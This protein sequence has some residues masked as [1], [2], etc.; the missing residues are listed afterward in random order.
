MS[1]INKS[2]IL[3]RASKRQRVRA[4]IILA[5]LGGLFVLIGLM[6]GGVID[7]EA[8]L[9][10]CGFKQ[11]HGLPC[12]TCGMTHS[13]L[14]FARGS[15]LK[16]FYIQPAAALGCCIMIFGAF[17]A[18]MTAVFGIY[19]RFLDSVFSKGKIKYAIIFVI[20]VIACGWA[21][22]LARALAASMQG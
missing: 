20:I 4:G 3:S 8:L 21:V 7:A 5:I 9:D 1:S 10:P 18:L 12:P 22:T 16:A 15:V 2:K 6:A 17:L 13:L 19:F 14:A 11:R